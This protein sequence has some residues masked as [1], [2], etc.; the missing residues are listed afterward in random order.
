MQTIQVGLIGY[1][2]AGRV[3]H[4]PTITAVNGMKLHAVRATN[5][6]A[7]ALLHQRFPEV[8][9][10]S[11]TSD[12][13]N[14][15]AI[16]LVV[17]A[18]PNTLHFPIAKEAL[19]AGK[20]V[21]V[22]KPFTIT[23]DEAD[24]LITLSKKQGRMLSVYHN[25][26]FDS[27]AR[28]VKKVIES[29]LLGNIV[30]LE[31]H[32]DRF[33]NFLKPNAWREEDAPGSGILYDLGAHLIDQATNLFRL[34]QAVFADTR[35]QRQGSKTVDAF[36]VILYYPQLKVTLK[37]GMLVKEPG[38]TS[39]VLGDKGSFVKW[40]MDVQEEALKAG[41]HPSTTPAWGEE[42]ESIWGTLNT[43]WNG[44]QFRGKIQSEK[45]DYAAYYQNIYDALTKGADVIVKPEEARNTI[46][47]IELAMQSA[48][49]K[50][51]I[52]FS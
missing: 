45:G 5:E 10:V 52:D 32:F 18:T 22:D 35:A 30:A 1:G 17:I 34:P 31:L 14:D 23:S 49:E 16:E 46:R 38:P 27:G 25:R 39:I 7:K 43:E 4:A 20:H 26:R 47:I 29:G 8:R 40:G 15:P 19:L 41:H 36:E 21:V 12:I 42:P 2:M 48:A 37:S 33:R 6:D 3:F 9:I 51:V 50:R 28:T 24:A 11:E 44:L 13:F